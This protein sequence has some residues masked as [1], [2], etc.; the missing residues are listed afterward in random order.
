MADEYDSLI[1]EESAEDAFAIE[2]LQVSQE[3]VNTENIYYPEGIAI[4]GDIQL[5]GTGNI[6]ISDPDVSWLNWCKKILSTPRYLCD[7]YSDQM[8]IDTEA[9]FN[10]AS[11]AEAEEILRSEINGALTADPYN[12]TAHVNSI[13]FNWIAP[14]AVEVSVEITGFQNITETIATTLEA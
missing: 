13:E 5:D 2:A 6:V 8:G 14:D 12:R 11:R 9:A 1:P 4:D 7:G 3:G 10:A